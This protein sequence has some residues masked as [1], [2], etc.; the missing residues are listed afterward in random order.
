MRI[1]RILILPSSDADGCTLFS[2]MAARWQGRQYQLIS[3]K[4]CD[5]G[6]VHEFLHVFLHVD[7]V[8]ST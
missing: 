3:H 2:T 5:N 6:G 4:E 7:L 1:S 8:Y